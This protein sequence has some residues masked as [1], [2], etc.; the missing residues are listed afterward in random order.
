MLRALPL[1]ALMAT[2]AAAAPPILKVQKEISVPVYTFGTLKAT[3]EFEFVKWKLPEALR[4]TTTEGPELTFTGPPGVYEAHVWASNKDGLSDLTTV[5]ITIGD[6][7]PTPKP[8]DPNVPTPT[9]K[10]DVPPSP[11]D[12]DG[13]R[14][15]LV[16]ESGDVTKMTKDQEAILYSK[17]VRDYLNSKCVVGPDNTTR[18]WRIYDQDTDVK[19]EAK[20]WQQA[21]GRPRK[22][23]P[24][25]LISTGKTGYE[26][27]LPA[28]I[29][30]TLT[31]LKKYA[32]Q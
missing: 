27:P 6:G 14:V 29:A 4:F 5:K 10:P 23:V 8:V 22:S 9:P 2:L 21:M 31:L 17:S 30:D 19:S 7:K 25:I 16:Y 24:W 26:G 1:V 11:L 3:G 20:V 13:F 32:E 18:E 12:I 28:N 15:L